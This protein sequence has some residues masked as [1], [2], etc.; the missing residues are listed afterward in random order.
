MRRHYH[1]RINTPS[2]SRK[3]IEKHKDFDALLER[4]QQDPLPKRT[5]SSP[6]RRILIAG[7][8]LAAGL[9]GWFILTNV[10]TDAQYEKQAGAYFASQ[11]YVAPPLDQ[12]IQKEYAQ[13]S[14]DAA[15]GGTYDGRNGTRLHIPTEAFQDAA[16][17]AISGN[18]DIKYR[19]MHDFVDFFLSGIPMA[20]DSAG[21][22]YQLESAGMLEIY[23]EQH[24]K[25]LQIRPGRAIEVE[26]VSEISVS[27]VE[28]AKAYNVYRLDTLQRN[29][30]YQDVDEM[31]IVETY[32]PELPEAHELCTVQESFQLELTALESTEQLALS[33]LDR[34]LAAPDPPLRPQRHNG[35]DFV[36]DFDL[37]AL[38]QA[39]ESHSLSQEQLDLLREGTLWQL[40]PAET[41]N[42]D[43]LAQQ[44]DDLQ[45]RPINS[46]DFQLT[47]FKGAQQLSVVVNPVLSG[48]NY[49]NALAEY[50][51]AMKQYELLTALRADQLR[52]KRDSV[53][54]HFAAEREHLNAR[55]QEAWAS[56]EIEPPPIRHKVINRF[57]ATHLGIWN[58][59]RP[60][61][62]KI[63]DVK[64]RFR[65]ES[66]GAL[67]NRVG[68]LVDVNKNT[69]TRF[70]TGRT[71]K[72]PINPD[73][74]QL[75]WMLTDEQQLAI[76]RPASTKQVQTDQ[77]RQTIVMDIVDR[78]LRNEIDIR[79]ALYS[80]L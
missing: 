54:A 44:W 56:V 19:E 25:R 53:L 26:L 34:E 24:G 59:D 71:A 57:K 23:A 60:M 63:A 39:P 40:H 76:C 8:S 14:F 3:D 7:M 77:G 17:N 74:D 5:T 64:A 62:P 37:S 33:D 27:D 9:A 36:F 16:G 70:Y 52:F 65:D 32:F 6:V 68:Y 15:Q 12:T 69:I 78:P 18:V 47:L 38:L 73:T 61:E 49:D 11:P 75:I 80:S 10:P 20:Y 35:T 22:Q 72:L 48:A 50:E 66:G 41:I 2:P 21:T 4:Y 31:I 55:Y 43:Q 30:V 28:E 29:W 79:E 45:L 46:R 1:F 51:A 58:C 67:R 42:R 13:F